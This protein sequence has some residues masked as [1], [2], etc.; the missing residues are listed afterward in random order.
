[1]LFLKLPCSIKSSS[2]NSTHQILIEAST[3]FTK[4]PDVALR[5]LTDQE[6]RQM[7]KQA[8]SVQHGECCENCVQGSTRRPLLSWIY[9]LEGGPDSNRKIA[10]RKAECKL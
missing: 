6:T 2:F 8:V 1:M 9:G 10:Q 3:V 5:K 4:D 7:N